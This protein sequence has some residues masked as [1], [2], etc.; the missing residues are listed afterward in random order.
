MQVK[1]RTVEEEFKNPMGSEG[2]RESKQ[3]EKY[4]ISNSHSSRIH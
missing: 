1:L 2:S 3:T 4:F